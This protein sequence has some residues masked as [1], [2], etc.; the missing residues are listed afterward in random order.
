MLPVSVLIPFAFVALSNPALEP[1]AWE[2]RPILVFGTEGDPQIDE[3]MALFSEA[4][5]ELEDRRNVIIVET[6]PS[7]DLWQHFRPNGFTVILVGLD[8]GE[9]FRNSRIT[10]PS[11]LN[12]LIDRMPM[13][14]NEVM[15]RGRN[16]N[17]GGG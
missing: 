3:Q 9:K 15:R 6:D 12:E 13:R 8:G 4:A 14:Q 7:S 17:M 11:E 1:F 2:K 5:L 16:P 10:D